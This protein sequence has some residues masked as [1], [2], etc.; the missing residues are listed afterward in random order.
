MTRTA[1]HLLLVNGGEGTKRVYADALLGAGY[2]VTTVETM[3]EALA[4]RRRPDAVIL[5]MV[6]PDGDLTQLA[7][8]LKSGRRRRAMTVIAL[9][10]EDHQDAVVKAGATFCRHPCPPD[11][12]VTLVREALALK[13]PAVRGAGAPQRSKRPE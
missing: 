7:K 1:P 12:L 4:S 8:T 11:D 10:A 9:G 3:R 5:E 13:P 6:I 2:R